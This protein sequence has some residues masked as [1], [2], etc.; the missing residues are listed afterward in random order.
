MP[1][2]HPEDGE[3]VTSQ[4]FAIDGRTDRPK[5]FSGTPEASACAE[6]A[7]VLTAMY[8]GFDVLRVALGR[9]RTE[10]HLLALGF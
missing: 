5:R 1:P 4:Y 10:Q 2:A 7:G 6:L 9:D 3:R 8:G